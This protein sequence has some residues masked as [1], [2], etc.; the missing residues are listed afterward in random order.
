VLGRGGGAKGSNARTSGGGWE[1]RVVQWGMDD[2]LGVHRTQLQPAI[3]C[4]FG[5]FRRIGAVWETIA[6]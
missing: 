2:G 3:V 4:D 5:E 1:E 6:M